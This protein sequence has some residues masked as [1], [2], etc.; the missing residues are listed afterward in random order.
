MPVKIWAQLRVPKVL[1]MKMNGQFLGEMKMENKMIYQ[2]MEIDFVAIMPLAKWL[3]KRFRLPL[4][5]ND[6]P[7]KRDSEK[8]KHSNGVKDSKQLSFSK[9]EP[10]TT[11][12]GNHESALSKIPKREKI[13]DKIPKLVNGT[14]EIK[15]ENHSGQT[16]DDLNFYSG[17]QALKRR[18]TANRVFVSE[19]AAEND[20]IA[21]EEWNQ[22]KK[23]NSDEERKNHAQQRFGNK[24][25]GEPNRNMTLHGYRRYL[26]A[27]K[28]KE[29]EQLRTENR[30]NEMFFENRRTAI[31][32][33]K[34]GKIETIYTNPDEQNTDSKKRKAGEHE[35]LPG[36]KR[37]KLM[38]F[39]EY[40]V[41]M[42]HVLVKYKKDKLNAGS[43]KS[44]QQSNK[45]WIY[46]IRHFKNSIEETH[47]FMKFYAEHRDKDN[48]LLMSGEE[49]KA[50]ECAEMIFSQFVRFYGANPDVRCK[51]CEETDQSMGKAIM[52]P[53]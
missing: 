46:Y 15:Q 13:D 25:A 32:K 2:S 43:H 42:S 23:L 11:K 30:E 10:G 44:A 8:T 36:A 24:H 35:D 28:N 39:K 40:E 53:Y 47:T 38:T 41:A 6:E 34:E 22:I 33:I 31:A 37:Q 7:I 5:K 27:K 3:A 29:C 14:T 49:L 4:T 16:P 45:N 12:K 17:V 18:E 21:A 50:N 48:N 26:K 51:D 52:H 19:D 1:A 9:Q 20:D